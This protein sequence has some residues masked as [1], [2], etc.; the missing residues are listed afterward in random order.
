MTEL[1]KRILQI[2]EIYQDNDYIDAE[3]LERRLKSERDAKIDA[4][5]EEYAKLLVP[6]SKL[7]GYMEHGELD[8]LNDFMIEFAPI[9]MFELDDAVAELVDIGIPDGKGCWTRC[10]ECDNVTCDRKNK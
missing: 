3:D 4:I 2:Y 5:N 1:R 7:L 9:V 10:S 8:K 6:L